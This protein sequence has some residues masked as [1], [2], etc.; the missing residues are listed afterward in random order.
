MWRCCERAWTVKIGATSDADGCCGW[1]L[2]AH[3]LLQSTMATN[4]PSLPWTTYRLSPSPPH[5]W[6]MASSHSALESSSL[7]SRE[8]SPSDG[9]RRHA[10]PD[11]ES[12][13]RS[14]VQPDTWDFR[15]VDSEMK[16]RLWF[17]WHILRMSLFHLVPAEAA[18]RREV[19]WSCVSGTDPNEDLWL[20]EDEDEEYIQAFTNGWNLSLGMSEVQ[21]ADG[22][23]ALEARQLQHSHPRTP[24]PV[25]HLTPQTR[26]RFIAWLIVANVHLKERGFTWM[27]IGLDDLIEPWYFSLG[28][29]TRTPE[30]HHCRRR[31][32]SINVWLET[33]LQVYSINDLQSIPWDQEC[34]CFPDALAAHSEQRPALKIRLERDSPIFRVIFEFVVT[35]WPLILW[36][37]FRT[38]TKDQPYPLETFLDILRGPDHNLFTWDLDD[39]AHLFTILYN[40]SLGLYPRDW[41]QYMVEID[42]KTWM[43]IRNTTKTAGRLRFGS[44]EVDLQIRISAASLLFSNALS[45]PQNI[46]ASLNV[47][48]YQFPF[49]VIAQVVNP[50]YQ[51][52]SASNNFESEE[53]WTSPN[54]EKWLSAHGQDLCHSIWQ[55]C[56][57]M[58]ALEKLKA[59]HFVLTGS[60]CDEQSGC[61]D[62]ASLLHLGFLESPTGFKSLI[63]K[64]LNDGKRSMENGSGSTHTTPRGIYRHMNLCLSV[65]YKNNPYSAVRL[66]T[67][68]IGKWLLGNR[69]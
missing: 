24:S 20:W 67:K 31:V 47:A 42:F 53:F 8:S 32:S 40:N 13:P 25:S 60:H 57:H 63:A 10:P 14:N 58:T 50:A 5:T 55:T 66:I 41:N 17:T 1:L 34:T 22:R 12:V 3:T 19:F 33:M 27:N 16:Y 6:T 2:P 23:R 56:S 46:Y 35:P 30:C 49:T 68:R 43:E 11:N 28:L 59:M 26:L 29:L 64:L 39:H 9:P 7:S 54:L 4:L 62:T 37:A 38:L 61:H 36:V 18:R 51:K 21:W 69:Q 52:H 44:S 65:C 45:I 48:V 15:K